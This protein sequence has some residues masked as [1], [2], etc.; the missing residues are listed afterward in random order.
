MGGAPRP[1]AA[2]WPPPAFTPPAKSEEP[3]TAAAPAP[4][5]TPPRLTRF[6]PAAVSPAAF[7]GRLQVEVILTIDVDEAGA[8][9]SVQ[10]VRSAG[11]ARADELDR[12]AVEAARQFTF[13]PG[14]ADGRPVPVRI[15]YSYNLVRKQPEAPPPPAPSAGPPPATASP[16]T[17]AAAAGA[18]PADR[19]ASTVRGRRF[20]R[21][22]VEQTLVIDE[23][24]R[25][26]GTQGDTL[27]A[28]QNLPGVSRAPFGIGLL[29]VWGSA[30]EDTRVYVDGVRIP[31]LYHFG[32]VRSTVNSEMVQSLSFVPGAYQADHGLGLGGVVEVATRSPRPDRTRGYAQIDLLDGSAMVEGRLSSSVS[33][34]VAGRRSWIDATLPIFTSSSLQLSPVYYDYQ[35]RLAWRPDPHDDVDVL[36]LG[37][38]DRVGIQARLKDEAIA[39]AVASHS[40]FHR[41]IASW[42]HRFGGRGSFSLTGSVGY[43]APFGLGVQ[44][45]QVPTSLDQRALSYTLRALATAPLLGD[46]VRVSGGVDFE[47]QRFVLTRSGATSLVID[48]ASAAG[49]AGMGA[50][51]GFA[52]QGSGFGAD[53]LIVYRN[54]VAPF[55]MAALSPWRSLTITPQLRC[56]ILTFTADSATG[57]GSDGAVVSPEPRLA[58]RYRPSARV[59]LRGAAGLYSQPPDPAALS[60]VFGNP[61]L[62]PERGA[63]YALGAEVEITRALHLEIDGFYKDLRR[64]VVTSA[65]AG[66][67]LLNNDGRGRAFGGQLLVRQELSHGFFGW[68]SYTWSRSERKDHPGE[69]WRRFELDQTHILTLV[70]SRQLPR[71][72][73]AGGRYRYVTGTPTTPVLGAFYDAVSDRYVPI[74]GPRYG[75][76]LPSFN[77]LDL[78]VDK[79]F[80]FDR[81]RLSVYLDVQNVLRAENPE[82]FGYNFDY[83]QRHPISGLPLLPVLGVR[84]DF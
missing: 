24:R 30:P 45:G 17:P 55:V 19:F 11:G 12:A 43:D 14:M 10:V 8:V 82:A 26:P 1:A 83:R 65:V 61:R 39:A 36:F 40:Y 59:A 68:L 75:A 81:W 66:A 62:V 42:A 34:A 3:R 71:G 69:G 38:D 20:T 70:L 79:T 48:P 5:F 16:R 46:A 73:Q 77:Q 51:G 72:F 58:V 6:V 29:A 49:N 57:A 47:G 27:K 76:R 31:V 13:T 18:P 78:R 56:Q 28:V 41:A 15:T 25:I 21:E 80:T 63:Q 37:S 23:I 22:T 4:A 7:E 33:Y 35:A 32:G 53:H 52:G 54:D 60:P 67:P 2:F 9:T 50:S 44:F 64:L 74:A 84:G